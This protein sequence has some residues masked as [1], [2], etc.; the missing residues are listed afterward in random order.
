VSWKTGNLVKILLLA[1]M[2]FSTCARRKS[3]KEP[4][5]QTEKFELPHIPFT[6][7]PKETTIR[8][9]LGEYSEVYIMLEDSF[10]IYEGNTLKYKGTRSPL[11][12]T[13]KR[14]KPANFYYYVSY[15][16]YETLSEAL[17]RGREIAGNGIKI[18]IREIGMTFKTKKGTYSTISY[19]VYQGPFESQ[20]EA[21]SKSSSQRKTI[22]KEVKTAPSGTLVLLFGEKSYE[23][24]N[25]IRIVSKS[26]IKLMNFQ[27]KN[28]YYGGTDRKP[29]LAS[30]IVEVRPSNSGKIYV[31]NEL[32][33]EEYVEGV[34]K[35]EVPVSF[36]KEALKAQAVA[37]RTNAI[38]TIKKKLSLFSEPFDATA[39][40]LTQNFDGFNNDPYLKSIVNETRGEVITYKNK[41]ISVFYHSSCGGALASSE[42]IFGKKLPYYTARRDMYRKDSSLFL[43]TDASVR[44]FIDNIT[45]ANCDEGNRYYR[46]ERAISASELSLNIG[47]K[48]GKHLGRILDIKVTKRGPSGRA[49][50][51]FIEGENSS[52]FIEGDFEIRRALDTNMLPS[53]LFYVDKVGE[54][55]V[56]RGAG[57]GHGVGMCQY[58]AAGLAKNGK[59][60]KEILTF[61]YYGTQIEKIY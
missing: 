45:S 58:G 23:V 36:P 3:L 42:E 7:S 43:Y 16:E 24:D 56:I 60:Y 15:G 10:Y 28:I 53:S 57:F 17:E 51:I 11:R 55:F 1:L 35:G 52:T 48:F 22:F 40:V 20:N 2:I 14:A 39:D 9:G 31:I 41:V 8:V 12:V 5:L 18:K 19:L 32:P 37:A 26:P 6:W 47:K 38:S 30:G 44:K 29:F 61:Y 13:I 4:Q 33:I 21:L 34:L 25:I 27:R 50:V 49:Q 59:S 54:I 46:W